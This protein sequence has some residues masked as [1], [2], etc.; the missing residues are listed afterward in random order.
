MFWFS[1]NNYG[2]FVKK[3]DT[4]V[5]TPLVKP[6]FWPV[7]HTAK[8]KK[9]LSTATYGKVCAPWTNW[10][11]TV[12]GGCGTWVRLTSIPTIWSSPKP[13]SLGENIRGSSYEKLQFPILLFACSSGWYYNICYWL[14]IVVH[15]Y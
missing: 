7:L 3:K 4:C 6:V 12:Y 1:K 5:T 14:T 9:G 11:F 13:V 2:I 10:V 15:T 8:F